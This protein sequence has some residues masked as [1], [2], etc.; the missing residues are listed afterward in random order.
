MKFEQKHRSVQGQ[1]VMN[2]HF[3]IF[4]ADFDQTFAA[5]VK[6]ITLNVLFV[7]VVFFHLDTDQM[8]FKIEFLYSFID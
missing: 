2:S 8:D 6:L 5:F 7:I 3:K 1:I 4:G